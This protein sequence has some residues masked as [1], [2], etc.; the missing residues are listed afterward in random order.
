[1]LKSWPGGWADSKAKLGALE[2]AL[3]FIEFDL[4]GQI[5][6]ANEN[7]CAAMGYRLDEIVGRHH[8]LFVDEKFRITRDYADFWVRLA[9]G[10]AY[11]Q[12]CIRLTKNGNEVLLQASYNP[13]RDVA[14]RIYKIVKVA[15]VVTEA[16]MLRAD[17]KGKLDAISRSQAIIEF[18]PDG[19]ILTANENFLEAMSYSLE[20]IVG[21]N[22]RIF[23][24][25]AIARG[26]D[27]A[28]FW[29]KLRQGGYIPLE[30]KRLDKNGEHV[31]L[32][33]SYNPIFDM[34]GHVVKV[35]KY[36]TVITGRVQAIDTIGK[37]LAKLADNIL[38]FRMDGSIDPTYE[39]LREDFNRAIARLDITLGGVWAAV[40]TVASGAN[41]IAVAS[42]DLAQRTELQAGSLERTAATLDDITARVARGAG[43]AKNAAH[44]ASMVRVDALKA[45]EVV[46]EAVA[47][48]EKMKEGSRAISQITGMIEQIAFQTNLLALNAAVEAARA[49]EAGRGFSV[50]ATEVRALAER[51]A[52][53][54][55]EIRVLI[56]EGTA[57][58][59]RGA[60]L[61]VDAGSAL[62]GIVEQ[63]SDIDMVLSEIA[64]G[65]V[66]QA[67]GLGQV[68]EAVG[69]LDRVTQ[70]NAAMVEEATAAANSLEGEA[71]RLRELVG[72][73]TLSEA[74]LP[75]I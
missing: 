74:L 50:V 48:M 59:D 64:H 35:V 13:V 12:E 56:A 30:C 5:L 73:F 45:N 36:A 70:Q 20:E 72:E 8:S 42:N 2:R 11:S 1:M 27:Y 3:A 60:Q 40:G 34:Y 55:K 25:P 19:T 38:S 49:G 15:A 23:I 26:A 67:E 9:S 46:T 52:K 68:N 41:E 57:H 71:G 32:Q 53:A 39:K 16:A 31:W 24:D 58:S 10:E 69:Q 61:I 47:A 51:S 75:G 7:F 66:E 33:A 22:H 17:T 63:I 28:E 65:S 43:S 29:E 21:K 14:G 6:D 37:G 44:S 54:S 62:S 4:K 18:L